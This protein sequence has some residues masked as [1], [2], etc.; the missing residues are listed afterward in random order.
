MAR[1]KRRSRFDR[2]AVLRHATIHHPNCPAELV[3]LFVDDISAREWE[4]PLTLG[5]AFG[6]KATNHV[7]HKM[8]DYDRLIRFP[9]LTR[10]EA[11]LIV[12]FEVR[13]ILASWARTVLVIK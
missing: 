4:P 2:E 9:G 8:T 13:S 5:Q 7:R 10:D 6:I 12:S 11:R 3:A 1:K